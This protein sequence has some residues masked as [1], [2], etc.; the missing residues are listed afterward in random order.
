MDM[1]IIY[2]ADERIDANG[3]QTQATQNRKKTVKGR[4]G[5]FEEILLASCC[6][7]Q[8]I[9]GIR[10]LHAKHWVVRASAPQKTNTGDA[11]PMV[12]RRHF[13]GALR[14]LSEEKQES[15][16]YAGD[17]MLTKSTDWQS[18]EKACK[19]RKQTCIQGSLHGRK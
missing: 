5:T 13:I 8:R 4:V 16:R 10:V 11:R 9:M 1:R 15:T 2:P 17:R 19:P 3:R 7:K 18:D 6:D 14:R 12:A